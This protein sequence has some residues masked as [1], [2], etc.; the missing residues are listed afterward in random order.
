MVQRARSR[1]L[2]ATANGQIRASIGPERPRPTGGRG[3]RAPCDYFPDPVFSDPDPD[4]ADPLAVRGRRMPGE[5]AVEREL[6]PPV[7]VRVDGFEAVPDDAALARVEGLVADPEAAALVRAAGL[8]AADPGDSAGAAAGRADA[9]L[10][11]RSTSCPKARTPCWS[12]ATP[13]P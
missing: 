3:S 1:H 4:P 9:A 5:D 10:A 6:A 7:R 2:P 13:S 8:A 12:R 11:E